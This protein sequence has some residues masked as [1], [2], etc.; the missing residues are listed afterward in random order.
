MLMNAGRTMVWNKIKTLINEVR[1]E[2]TL[3]GLP[4]VYAGAILAVWEKITVAQIFWI[5]LSV[6]GARIF[7]MLM[8]RIIDRKIDEK[9]PR[10]IARA[11]PAGNLKI[12]EAW[13]FS[14]LSLSLYI[15]A[16]FNLTPLCRYL[17][18]IPLFF[19]IF[20]PYTKRFT[21]ITHFFLGTTLGLAPL[22]GWIAVRNEI[23]LPPFLLFLAV[24]LWVSG[25]DIYYAT[26]D[27]E[28][29]KKEGIY[30]IPCRFGIKPSVRLTQTLHFFAFLI[31]LY[32]GFVLSLSHFYFV[33][34]FLSGAFLLWLDIFYS[35]LHDIKKVDAYLQKNGY[36][37]VIFFVF[38]FISIWWKI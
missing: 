24:L 12:I 20:Y 4:F 11:L 7:A 10:T 6:A 17:F 3:F 33:G 9:N 5:T 34:V 1:M 38:T 13:V 27:Y 36:F 30:S 26:Q 18:P 37:S 25:F 14:L 2:Q 16:A 8:N 32:L 35:P 23:S 15:L 31:L 28:F 21:W 22:A 19:F 29:D